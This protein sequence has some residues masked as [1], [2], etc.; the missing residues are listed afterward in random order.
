MERIDELV[1]PMLRQGHSLYAIDQQLADQLPCSISTLYRLIE[2][3]ELNAHNIDLPRKVRFK[4]SRPKRKHKIDKTCRIGRTWKDYQVFLER[5][6]PSLIVQGDTMEGNKGGA[7]VLSL[8]WIHH[9]LIRLH[10]REHNDARSVK[11]VP[12]EYEKG[13]GLEGFR[14]LFPVLLLDNGP[15]F[16]DP[17]ALEF[18]PFTGERRTWVFYCDPMR[19]DQKG[20]L[21][22]MHRDVR[23]ILPKGK[24]GCQHFIGQIAK[25][26]YKSPG[27]LSATV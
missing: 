7:V 8:G 14:E 6:E 25:L 5:E 3:G 26:H 27:Y 18:S 19:A 4:P 2:D 12:D 23:R 20:S 22:A 11:E 24:P 13:L 10:N 17:P 1:L 16:S 9:H 21:E 15:E